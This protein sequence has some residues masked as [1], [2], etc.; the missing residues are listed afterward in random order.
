[1]DKERERIRKR[2]FDRPKEVAQEPPQGVSNIEA[3]PEI[4]PKLLAMFP[5]GRIE[6]LMEKEARRYKASL[7]KKW[8][9]YLE[10]VSR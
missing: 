4:N 10:S 1:M 7:E 5:S 2:V 8:R 9:N 6:K 3:N